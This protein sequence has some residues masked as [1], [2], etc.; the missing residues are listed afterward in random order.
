MHFIVCMWSYQNGWNSV[1]GL[2]WY[3]RRVDVD[4]DI[5]RTKFNAGLLFEFGSVL[6]WKLVNDSVLKFKEWWSVYLKMMVY[7]YSDVGM[8]VHEGFAS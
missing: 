2:K 4:L 8:I 3:G 7:E 5:D 6:C 1:D